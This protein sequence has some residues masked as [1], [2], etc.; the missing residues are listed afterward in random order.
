MQVCEPKIRKEYGC[1]GKCSDMSAA[2]EA[3]KQAQAQRD[4]SDKQ[5]DLTLAV[6]E[7]AQ[8]GAPLLWDD[9]RDY[10][11]AEVV[12]LRRGYDGG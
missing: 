6:A 2:D 4:A 12:K 10:M 8:S 7:A 3:I 1:C 5:D 9:I 11:E